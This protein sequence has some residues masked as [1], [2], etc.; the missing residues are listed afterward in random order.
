MPRVLIVVD[1][2]DTLLQLQ[3]D[4]EAGGYR[5]TLAADA[6][7]ALER[8]AAVPIDAVL[9]DV[10]MPVRDGW[11]VL[12]ALQQRTMPP[13][14]IVVSG[15]PNSGSLERATRLGAT[16]WLT[17]PVSAA[18]LNDAVAHA[19]GEA[20]AEPSGAPAR[21]RLEGPDPVDA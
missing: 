17:V 20:P 11:T 2:P 21:G 1:E 18:D 6:D 7:T 19:L 4:L 12:E 13:P 10:M 5:T 8:L 15:A 3:A 14:A 16:G 9:L